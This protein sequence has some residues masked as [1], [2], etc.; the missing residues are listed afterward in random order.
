MPR[1]PSDQ[2][3]DLIYDAAVDPRLWD[4]VLV[5]PSTRCGCIFTRCGCIFMCID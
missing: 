1:A 5:E 4:R 3:I 2:L